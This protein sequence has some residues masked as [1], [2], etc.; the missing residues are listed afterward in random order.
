[1][2][3]SSI[4]LLA[5]L[6]LDRKRYI[7]TFFMIQDKQRQLVK[8]KLN[9]PQLDFLTRRSSRNIIVK[10]RQLGFSTVILADMLAE[11]ITVPNTVCVCISHEERATQ[12]LLKKVH[13]MYDMIPAA[14]RDIPELS[15]LEDKL[16]RPTAH[17]LSAYEVT[18][19]S[20]GSSFFIGTARAPAFGRGDTI[21]RLHMSELAHYPPETADTLMAAVSQSVPRDGLITIESNPRGRGGVFYRT[22]DLAKQGLEYK[23]FFYPW[24]WAGEYRLPEGDELALEADRYEFKFTEDEAALAEKNNLNLEQIRW[25]RFKKQELEKLYNQDFAQEYP[26][27]DIDCWLTG[28][29]SVFDTKAIRAML[30]YTRQPVWFDQNTKLW[31]LPRGDAKYIIGVD[32]AEGLP[33]SDWSVSSVVELKNCVH[34]GT[35]RARMP[36][37]TFTQQIYQ[38]AQRYNNALVVVERNNHGLTVLELLKRLGYTRIYEHDDKRPGWRT[39]LRTRPYMI[40]QLAIHLRTMSLTS[41]DETFLDEALGF[42]YLDGKAQAPSD[43]HDDCLFSMML[44]LVVRNKLTLVQNRPSLPV[45]RYGVEVM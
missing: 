30:P 13:L 18:F 17:H 9:K 15:G 27:N 25:R 19:P 26:E 3:S 40:D 35:L 39:D 22:Y 14:A 45:Q 8:L 11:A 21:H 20:I 38:L 36:I 10:A 44:C 28:G 43:G 7:E 1:M 37:D 32:A 4:S 42:Q 23:P 16:L 12:R 29:Q 2:L 5:N 33:T 6:V 31:Q 24:W 41:W 34:V